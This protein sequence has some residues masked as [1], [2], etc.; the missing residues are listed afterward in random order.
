M[1][2]NAILNSPY[3]EP[4]LHYATSGGGSLDYEH[5]IG[6]RRTFN[7]DT[8]TQPKH[9]RRTKQRSFSFPEGNSTNEQDLINLCRK[10][11]GL[12]LYS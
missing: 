10:E 5:V 6:G 3:D 11:V 12:T 4:R 2:D 1:S 7:P 9:T 8:E